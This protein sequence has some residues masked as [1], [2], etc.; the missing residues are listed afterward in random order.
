MNAHEELASLIA[1]LKEEIET[2]TKHNE[3][4]ADKEHAIRMERTGHNHTIADKKNLLDRMHRIKTSVDY[5]LNEA[6][7]VY[8]ADQE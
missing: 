6:L 1:D 8:D 7:G 5:S 2:L 3:E 4:L